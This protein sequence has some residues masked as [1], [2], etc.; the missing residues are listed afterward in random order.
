MFDPRVLRFSYEKRIVKIVSDISIESTTRK[1]RELSWYT[2]RFVVYA[3]RLG[4]RLTYY[5]CTRLRQNYFSVRL[6]GNF[7]PVVFELCARE[8]K[9]YQRNCLVEGKRCG[10]EEID[11]L[12]VDSIFI[13]LYG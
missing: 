9:F 12:F 1:K 5:L 11:T 13:L 7:S 8:H 4:F 6:G 10:G 3:E 2:F